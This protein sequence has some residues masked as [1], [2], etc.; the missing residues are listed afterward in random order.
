MQS[1]VCVRACAACS[2]LSTA[3]FDFSQ[4][5]LAAS[6]PCQHW[7]FHNLLYKCNVTGNLIFCTRAHNKTPI[8]LH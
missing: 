3:R 2:Q 1:F 5:K 8:A 7:R 4:L 6:K